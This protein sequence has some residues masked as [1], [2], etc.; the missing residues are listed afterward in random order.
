MNSALITSQAAFF[1]YIGFTDVTRMS[2]IWRILIEGGTGSPLLGNLYSAWYGTPYSNVSAPQ[3]ISPYIGNE[4]YVLGLSRLRQLRVKSDSCTI[5]DDFKNEIKACYADY[6]SRLEE[7]SSFGPYAS[8]NYT[9]QTTYYAWFW[10]SETKLDGTSYTGRM[11]S[12]SG[13]GYV[14]TLPNN[15]DDAYTV[16]MDLYN[17]LWID[18]ATRVVFFDVMTYNPNINLFCQTKYDN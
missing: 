3:D 6:A 8:E 17:N 5:P 12:Y 13:S 16:L 15:A 1:P 18:R 10:N 2:D 4:N 14:Q 7:K 11:N 9:N